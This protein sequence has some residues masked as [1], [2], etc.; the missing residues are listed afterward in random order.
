MWTRSCAET[1]D[2]LR[3][4]AVALQR[5][6]LSADEA[7]R[8]AVES[9]GKASSLVHDLA[10]LDRE[11]VAGMLKTATAFLA[12]MTSLAALVTI[13]FAFKVPEDA[14][15]IQV[16]ELGLG[17]AILIQGIVTLIHIF[18]GKIPVA[19]VKLGAGGL[20]IMG[21]MITAV[22]SYNALF[23]SDP[24]YWAVLLG[25]FLIAQA[26]GTLIDLHKL[27]RTLA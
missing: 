1:E 27:S 22:S 18:S 13:Y 20:L 3:E 21:L 23:G 24:E 7:E 19:V 10:E 26:V 25:G 9:F 4:S 12:G 15:W 16:V 14:V 8:K 5:G 6:G 11:G 2:H 17:G